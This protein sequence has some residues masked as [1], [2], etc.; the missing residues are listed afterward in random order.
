[1]VVQIAGGNEELS[2]EPGVRACIV[3]VGNELLY[4]ETVDTNAAWMGRALAARGISVVR[5][6][7]VADLREEIER[8]VREAVDAADLVLVSG[9]LGPTSDDIT[10]PTVAGLF[11]AP[12]EIDDAL[13]QAL[14]DRFEARGYGVLPE[15]NVSQ[16]EVPRGARVLHNAHGTAPGLAMRWSDTWVVLLPGVPLELRGIFDGALSELMD[17]EFSDRVRP[18]SHRAIHT[19]GVPESLLAGMIEKAFAQAP[20]ISALAPDVSLA[21]LPDLRGVDLRLTARGVPV[22]IAESQFRQVLERLEPIVEKWRFEAASGDIVESVCDALRGGGMRLATAESCTAGLIAKRITDFPGASEVYSGG[23]VAY[24]NAVK[25]DLLEVPDH[26]LSAH[27]AVS[28]P[29]AIHMAE[30]IARRLGADVSV[31]VT[32]VAGPGGGTDQKPV[33]TVWL[34]VSGPS[35]VNSEHMTFVGDRHAVRERAAQ[36]ALA[37]VLRVLQ[38]SDRHP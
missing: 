28:E 25:K 12:I 11:A 29:V 32:G 37:L 19:T 7:T 16:A 21:Y 8:A 3:S 34:A 35:G 4:G 33:G 18:V 23:V 17:S 26:V 14:R 9:G 27:G 38:A 10:R 15:S 6:Y 13:L 36:A 22:D 1:M 20:D 2:P 30:G 31:A 5:R 24:D